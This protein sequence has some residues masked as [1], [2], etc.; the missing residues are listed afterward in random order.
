MNA[1]T[2]ETQRCANPALRGTGYES[3]GKLLK[4]SSHMQRA[5]DAL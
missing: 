2:L 5:T 1:L 3:G 4:S